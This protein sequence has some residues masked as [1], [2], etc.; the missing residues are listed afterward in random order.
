MPVSSHM[1]Q[2]ENRKVLTNLIE[3]TRQRSQPRGKIWR[4]AQENSLI[5]QQLQAKL[6]HRYLQQIKT[7]FNRPVQLMSAAQVPFLGPMERVDRQR[8]TTG[9]LE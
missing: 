4:D 7:E 9:A 5:K 2:S 3:T 1:V 8:E 6:L